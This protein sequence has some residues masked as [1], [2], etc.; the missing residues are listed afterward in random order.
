MNQFVL[1]KK[2][3]LKCIG[4]INY[5]Q[6][7]QK[8]SMHHIDAIRKSSVS[9]EFNRTRNLVSSTNKLIFKKRKGDGKGYMEGKL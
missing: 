1:L 9:N 2:L 5:L 7:I 8:N 6:E 4:L 3:N